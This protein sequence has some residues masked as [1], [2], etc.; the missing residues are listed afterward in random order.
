M[1]WSENPN[2]QAVAMLQYGLAGG[3]LSHAYIFHGPKGTGK[4][5]TARLFA[6][7]LFCREGL[8]EACGRCVECRKFLHDN[9][10]DFHPILPEGASIKIDQIREL[11]KEFSFRTASSQSKIYV[12]EQAEKM[13]VQASNSLLK[14]LEEPGSQVIA[15]LLTE[16][17]HAL[18]P[19]IRSRAQ[20]I[21]FSPA[22]PDALA[23]VLIGE[24]FSPALVHP[25]VRISAGLDGAREIIQTNWFAEMLSVMI[26]LAKESLINTQSA[27]MTVNQKIVKSELMDHI[28]TL[29]DLWVLWYKDMIQ[30]QWDR[31]DRIVF[32]DQLDWMGTHAFRQVPAYWIEAME[33]VVELRKRLRFHVNPQLAL[34]QLLISLER[35]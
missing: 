17:G 18:L 13:T 29:L 6:Q 16:N 31:K 25:A 20:W 21:P 3:K 2:R 26:Q 35:R 22:A 5:K 23:P 27:L 8:T 7:T 32:K 19:T 15:L 1:S 9:H 28:D 11:Q 33:K 4:R 10:P 34:E 30:L 24:G 12:I 14:F